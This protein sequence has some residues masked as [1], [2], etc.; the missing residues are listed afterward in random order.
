MATKSINTRIKN[1]VDTL[2][3]WLGDGVELLS[4]E[5]AVVRVPTE[6]T[7]VNP[8]TGA[9]ESVTE[10]LMKVGDGTSSFDQLPWLS[11]KASDVYDWAK[12]ADPGTISIKYND[13]TSTTP[14]WKYYTLT[15]F[16]TDAV[17]TM[18]TTNASLLDKMKKSVSGSNTDAGVL[19][20]ASVGTDGGLVVTKS[21]VAA[22]DIA[23]NA[24]TS[25]KIASNA[26]TEAKI[27][28]GAVTADKIANSAVT[29][30]KID[31][32]STDKVTIG[33]ATT[34]SSLT[35]KLS[36][37]EAAISNKAEDDHVH[38]NIE[39]DGTI[40]STAVTTATGVLVYDSN[41]KIQ[42]ATAANARSIIGAATSSHNHDTRYL[43]YDV[44]QTLNDTQKTYARS[45]IGA[46][47]STDIY[48]TD[49]K[50]GLSKSVSDNTAAITAIQ[51]AIAN[52]VDFIG[53]TTTDITTDPAKTT[54]TVTISSKPV[55]ADKGD[56]VIYNATGREFI[57]D[58][59]KWEELGDATR[60]GTLETKIDGFNTTTTNAVASTHKFVSEVTQTKGQIAV[61][62]TQPNGTD[63]LYASGS[64]D[65]VKDK[66]DEALADAAEAAQLAGHSHPYL[67]GATKYAGSST[68]GGAATSANKVNKAVIFKNDGSGA[69][70]GTTFDGST[71]RTISY[72]TI[73]AAAA[74]HTH[75]DYA[76]DIADIK[77]DYVR[78]NSTDSK[79]YAPVGDNLLEII[80]D[81][82]GAAGH[83]AAN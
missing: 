45:N 50:G 6:D 23:S 59:S 33:T 15:D 10:L 76:G 30:A 34:G 63:V 74:S 31:S 67:P 9:T 69:A 35:V 13:G 22:D 53:V 39:N 65:T 47:S 1:R 24:V 20:T 61:K 43:R 48:G 62:Y 38:G 83:T 40:K 8:D 32:V 36:T 51:N 27:N 3:A 21:T 14:S 12:S 28:N 2:S 11:A 60:I 82:G 41:N 19:K 18:K 54:A 75:S 42:R 16:I 58:G 79:L 49:G 46:V 4:G 29:N 68:Q 57:W 73:G 37:M 77:S 5:I 71:A 78:F 81:C 26:V 70:S 25:G 64:T 66:I 55:T 52:G 17:S 80:F 7:Y 72:N 56:I 44:A